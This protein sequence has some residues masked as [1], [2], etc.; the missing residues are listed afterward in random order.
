[1]N[2]NREEWEQVLERTDLVGGDL[3]TNDGSVM[4]RGPISSLEV[5]GSFLHIKCEWAATQN[6]MGGWQVFKDEACELTALNIDNIG[7]QDIGMQRVYWFN[8]FDCSTIFP[9]GGS[10]LEPKRVEGLVIKQQ[11]QKI[12]LQRHGHDTD[13]HLDAIGLN[14]MLRAV[15]RI[16]PLLHPDDIITLLSSPLARARESAQF[17]IEPLNLPCQVKNELNKSP[18]DVLD[19][20]SEYAGL[21]HVMICVTHLPY[22]RLF[23]DIFRTNI[24]GLQPLHRTDDLKTTFYGT[25]VIDAITGEIT[26]ME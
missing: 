15:E 20:I 24:L 1:M 11:L 10:K 22:L 12:I 7:P 26:V 17:F 14:Q 5:K 21:A 19:L 3:E 25:V 4:Y 16:K 2:T 13:G 6:D 23:P 8:G 9:K 18:R